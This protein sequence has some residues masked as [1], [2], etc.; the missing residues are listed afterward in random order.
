[1]AASNTA[2]LSVEVISK[3]IK[4]ATDKLDSLGYAAER[5]EKKVAKLTTSIQTLMDVQRQSATV[6]A[7]HSNLMYAIAQAMGGIVRASDDAASHVRTLNSQ[8]MLLTNVN[9]NL[10]N[11][12]QAT[13]R[14]GGVVNTTLRAMATA[15]SAYL[16]L[17]FAKSIID[18]A[19]G[20]A[21]MQAKLRM[22]TGS[23][24]D[25]KVVQEDLFKMAQKLRAPLEDMGKLYNRISAPMEKMGKSAKET[26]DQVE[27][28][29]ASLKLNG[30]SAAEASSVMLQYSQSVNAG[31]LNGGEF[32]A[33]AEAAPSILRDIEAELKA[34]GNA[35]FANGKTLK[36]MG[37]DGELSFDLLQ[38]ASARALPRIRQEMANLPETVDG[39]VT[40]IKNAWFKAMGELGEDTQLGKK[41]N[42]ALMVLEDNIPKIRDMMVEV[43][44]FLVN[45]FGMITSALKLMIGIKLVSWAGEA[46][47]ALAGLGA[48]IN[49]LRGGLPAITAAMAGAGGAVGL[50][51]RAASLLAGPWGVM[52]GLV[53][54]GAVM[55]YQAF[56]KEAPKAESA[57]TNSTKI[58]TVNRVALI[59]KEINKIN[60]LK[61]VRNDAAGKPQGESLP[62]DMAQSVNMVLDAQKKYNEAVAA[63]NPA[64]IEAARVTLGV[65]QARYAAQSAEQTQLASLTTIRKEAEKQAAIKA[66]RG[67]FMEEFATKTEK[68]TKKIDEWKAKFKELGITLN[69]A[70]IKRMMEAEMPKAPKTGEDPFGAMTAS[71]KA[72]AEQL[73]ETKLANDGLTKSQIEGIKLRSG[74]D[75]TFNKLSASQ[76]A[77]V[78]AMVD[79]NAATEKQMALDK[80]A[81]KNR[82]NAFEE[83][84][85]YLKSVNDG[86]EAIK[87]QI[88]TAQ[89]QIAALQE[90]KLAAKEL[91]AAELERKASIA[92][93]NAEAINQMNMDAGR[94]T[95]DRAKALMAQAAA[96]RELAAT[97]RELGESQ[98]SKKAADAMAK[99][100]DPAK[101]L[102]FGNSLAG[103][104]GK[105]GGAV[106]GVTKALDQYN[107]RM[108]AIAAARKDVEKEADPIKRYAYI[109]ELDKKEGKAKLRHYGDIAGAA[110][111]F[112]K[113]HTA[114]YKVLATTEKAFRAM[115]LA[116]TV[117]NNAV[118][119]G[120]V[121][122]YITAK[123]AEI[124]AMFTASA[125][126]D[127]TTGKSIGNSVAKTGA[128]LIAGAAKMF[129]Q[130]GWFGFAGVAA[131]MAVMAGLGFGGGGSSGPKQMGF[132]ERQKKQGTGGVLG[133]EEAKSKSITNALE[134]LESN[135]DVGL[136]YSSGM[137]AALQSIN[138]GIGNMARFV[139]QG[140]GMRMTAADEA[141]FGVGSSKSALGF[142]KSST[143]VT[144]SGIQ[145]GV[146]QTVGSVMDQV[147][148]Q[149]YADI[150]KKKSSAWGL[151]KSTKR[152]TQLGN[153]DDALLEQISMT[154]ADFTLGIGAAADA[155]GM[156]GDEVA[157]QLQSMAFNIDRISLKGLSGEEIAA[158]L[159]A[160]FGKLGDDMARSAL[161]GFDDFQ[162]VGEGYFETVI[163]VANGLEV[164]KVAL[165]RIGVSAV[166]YNEIMNKQGDIATELVRDSIKVREAGSNIG[167][168]MN[169]MSGSA[170]ELV[171]NYTNLLDI[172]DNLK[173]FG[174]GHQVT[175][176]MIAGAGGI[177]ALVG[178][179]ENYLDLLPEQEQAA[180]KATV[181]ASQFKR[182]GVEMPKTNTALVEMIKG[183]MSGDAAS[184]QLGASLM[185]LA[186]GF[187]EVQSTYEDLVSTARDE[188]SEAYENEADALEET[189]K[190]F[191]DF[192]KSLRTFRDSLM[193]GASSPLTL[194]QKYAELTTQYQNN[195][196]L[197]RSGDKD[198]IDKYQTLANA[199]LEASRAYNASGDAYTSDFYSIMQDSAYLAQVADSQASV[200]QQQLDA[201]NA[202]VSGLIEVKT[203]V[204]T[205][206]E[207]ITKLHAAMTAA[208]YAVDGSHANGLSYVPFDGYKAELHEGERV[209]TKA[210]NAAY[211]NG[212]SG[213]ANNA[214]MVA[215]LK[216]LRTEL[217]S[218]REEQKQQT[219]AIIGAAYDSNERNAKD[220]VEG[221][222][223]AINKSSW[224]S[225]ATI[226]LV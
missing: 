164:G 220:V 65:M 168:M 218:L 21:M 54:T 127:A 190:K 87:A 26:M 34:T 57:V 203:S 194:A 224:N 200:A 104:F 188:L 159:E 16:S 173:A 212:N 129:E 151:S 143:E 19:D 201:L 142:S 211:M 223:D 152:S 30:A 145:F 72:Q 157:S 67:Q 187:A 205:V 95:D 219:G 23:L 48:G 40:R 130:S 77:Q 117:K 115:E 93:A 189:R 174:L 116:E 46:A 59:Q 169:G 119:L 126:D 207:A 144:D 170:S 112:F 193:T 138:A 9:Q 171:E 62:K 181:M 17:N 172:Q 153:L 39:A 68:A 12:M 210:E 1:M 98:D 128:S 52:I 51:T 74:A 149:S 184:Q 198:A 91:T 73:K 96:Y 50:L 197:A 133:D 53:G 5:N 88:V 140:S 226:G 45:N 111:G 120:G 13:A 183:Y 76:K 90:G 4:D 49:V 3:G 158:E 108:D 125:A 105:I 35:A 222:E 186:E 110:K 148:A 97:Q 8:L 107:D 167:E 221:T 177:D 6:A 66:L 121:W 106:G 20:W 101:A 28:L 18:S 83:R 103:A 41:F 69:D 27:Y 192:G 63:G 131:M 132:E 99:L 216:A 147:M 217:S 80:E 162:K 92:E 70:E 154:V 24:E 124:A 64:M 79:A 29:A 204:M 208:G 85:K 213:S 42:Q 37:A 137:L 44:N 179:M 22:A 146:G 209:L 178:S 113:E 206:T 43:F 36:Q 38:R 175:R 14:S 176:E 60:E 196:S 32:N 134:A 75:A 150:T 82:A 185:N 182:L 202:Q 122:T 195:L 10:T 163:R 61:G 199:L 215:E 2:T 71:A 86:T 114:G 180:A 155:L 15:A 7:Q 56:A 55:A 135:A 78:L 141:R 84:T 102:D 139:A 160:V 58:E 109:A 136:K 123:G 33:V 47:G 100:L 161:A 156:K 25:A 225:K 11:S 94:N 118:K 165:Q 89:S 81:E 214:A 31:R 191:E 166:S